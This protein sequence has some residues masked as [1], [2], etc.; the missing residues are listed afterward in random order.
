MI[1]SAIRSQLRE[2][3]CIE[4]E[5]KP[6]TDNQLPKGSSQ[7]IP[8]G[9]PRARHHQKMTESQRITT[10]IRKRSP[11]GQVDSYFPWDSIIFALGS[12][13]KPV[14]LEELDKETYRSNQSWHFRPKSSLS[15]II[16][17]ACLPGWF[18]QPLAIHISSY[19]WWRWESLTISWETM[20]QKSL[21]VFLTAIDQKQFQLSIAWLPLHI[22][23][24]TTAIA[25]P[26]MSPSAPIP[27]LHS[28]ISKPPCWERSTPSLPNLSIIMRSS[29]SNIYFFLTTA[30]QLLLYTDQFSFPFFSDSYPRYPN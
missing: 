1:P 17:L 4:R 10:N 2:V 23:S 15:R 19:T 30:F 18:L 14:R 16:N 22:F 11:N 13:A 12:T 28:S 7:A 5:P 29:W 20:K 3:T 27:I 25:Y 21:A 9:F 24:F 26:L 6:T 8:Q